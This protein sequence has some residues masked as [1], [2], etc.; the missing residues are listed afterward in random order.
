MLE[1]GL[2][3]EGGAACLRESEGGAWDLPGGPVVETSPSRAGTTGLIPAREAKIPHTLQPKSQN[4]S[5]SKTKNTLKKINPNRKQGAAR[6]HMGKEGRLPAGPE[7]AMRGHDAPGRDRTI[8]RVSA[9]V[10]LL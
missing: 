4:W 3:G 6:G 7:A 9:E 1:E 8:P 10:W 2:G 5:T